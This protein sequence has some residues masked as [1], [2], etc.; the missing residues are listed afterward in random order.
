MVGA[1]G[2]E[3]VWASPRHF[4]CLASTNFAKP[5]RCTDENIHIR[6][7]YPLSLLAYTSR[8][9]A[10]TGLTGS[11]KARGSIPPPRKLATF[12]TVANQP[13]RQ[14]DPSGVCQGKSRQ[15]SHGFR[16]RLSTGGKPQRPAAGDLVHAIADTHAGDRAESLD[17]RIVQPRMARW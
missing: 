4:K 12:E 5:R 15:R 10:R 14:F 9:L 16:C 6:D 17:E 11:A 8:V 7:S 3:P 13:V 2:I 1:T